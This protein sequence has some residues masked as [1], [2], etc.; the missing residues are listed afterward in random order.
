MKPTLF[1]PFIHSYGLMLAVGFYLGWWLA[2][3]RA[4]EQG[5][6]PDDIGNIVLLAIVAGVGGSRLLYFWQYRKPG[7]PL[8]HIIKVWEGG[9]VF[10][11]GLI[12][13][14]VAV[15][16]YLHWR[17]ANVWKLADIIAPSAAIGQ[18][19]GRIGC[20]LNGCCFGG[21]CTRSFPL[22][23]RFPGIFDAKGAATGSAP[24]LDHL[25]EQHWILDTARHS[26]A[27]HPTQ[28]YAS[29]SLFTIAALVLVAEP[30]KKRHGELFGLVIL[31]NAL[32]RMGIELV[33][34]D[35]EAVVL[36]L[37]GGQL[38]ALAVLA[39][40]IVIFIWARRRGREAW[41]GG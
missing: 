16:L 40:G 6:D 38:G 17:K 20:F 25:V 36:G 34:R 19:F 1:L 33:R 31:L 3:R 22:G 28:L 8:W 15:G 13:A 21:P 10:Y 9:L 26:L 30:W 35:S 12:G 29:L 32:S 4:R 7:E 18:A 14:A 27:V 41:A 37:K 11:G 2:A 39:A 23:V 5:E 24:Y